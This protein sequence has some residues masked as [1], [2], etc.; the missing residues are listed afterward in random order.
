MKLLSTAPPV[1]YDPSVETERWVL[2]G[3]TVFIGLALL[4]LIMV[5][6]RRRMQ[7]HAVLL[8]EI[9]ESLELTESATGKYVATTT[10]GQPYDR[11]AAGGLAFRGTARV[12]VHPT[13]ILIERTGE[14]DL[15]IPAAAIVGVDRATWTIDRVVEQGGLQFIRWRLGDREVDTYLR[16]DEPHALDTALAATRLVPSGAGADAA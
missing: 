12:S 14:T 8:P 3:V 5:G 11:I 2:L 1:D 7:K 15:W 13:G 16:M 6:W 4:V 9:P 10:A